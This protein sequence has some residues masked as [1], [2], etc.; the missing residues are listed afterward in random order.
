MEYFGSEEELEDFLDKTKQML[1]QH[2]CPFGRSS[3]QTLELTEE[4]V[5]LLNGN[6]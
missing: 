1:D 3:T 5:E 6:R 2:F 4:D